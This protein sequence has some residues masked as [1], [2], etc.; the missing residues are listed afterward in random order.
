MKHT[1]ADDVIQFMQ[2]VLDTKIKLFLNY[3]KLQTVIAEEL[4]RPLMGLD[5]KLLLERLNELEDEF[6]Q[7]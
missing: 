6:K 4:S 3:D 1:E 2:V 7:S 5:F